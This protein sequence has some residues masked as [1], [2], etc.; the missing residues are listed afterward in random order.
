MKLDE[1]IDRMSWKKII[2]LIITLFF[3]VTL[4]RQIL[5]FTMFHHAF[6]SVANTISHE[7]QRMTETKGKFDKN[8]QAIESDFDKAF[9]ENSKIMDEAQQNMRDMV[10]NH[11]K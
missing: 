6:N 5:M 1:I 10:N 2:L 11:E 9:K 3:I 4:V 8:S 7:E